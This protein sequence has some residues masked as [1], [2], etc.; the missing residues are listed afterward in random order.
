MEEL[1]NYAEL[2]FSNPILLD[3]FE[4]YISNSV[5]VLFVSQD[6]TI[7]LKFKINPPIDTPKNCEQVLSLL[8]ALLESNSESKVG[9]AYAAQ[10]SNI[11]RETLFRLSHILDGFGDVKLLIFTTEK[12]KDNSDSEIT[13]RTEFK[14]SRK[15]ST[16][17]VNEK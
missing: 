9:Q 2:T 11:L 8:F 3:V 1:K 12:S 5:L 14:L 13:R 17:T 16:S 10:S 4:K 6:G 7:N 15:K